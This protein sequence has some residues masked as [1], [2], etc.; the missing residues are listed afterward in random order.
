MEKTQL[1]TIDPGLFIN[2]YDGTISHRDMYDYLHF[3]RAGYQKFCEPILEE[4]Q[5]LLKDFVKSGTQDPVD[6]ATS[7]G[8]HVWW[9]IVK[10]T[11]QSSLHGQVNWYG[12]V[13]SLHSVCDTH[14]ICSINWGI[15][16]WVILEIN[17]LRKWDWPQSLKCVHGTIGSRATTGPMISFFTPCS[18]HSRFTF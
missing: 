7:Q 2:P 1:L 12:A 10:W 18:G 13:L 8:D 14:R 6:D 17:I 11:I 16:E 15:L 3:T 9:E 5:T 4:I